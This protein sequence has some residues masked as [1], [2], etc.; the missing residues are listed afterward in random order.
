MMFC[1][2]FVLVVPAT[3]CF[4]A[5]VC[6]ADLLGV[7][8][9]GALPLW[10]PVFMILAA[11]FLHLSTSAKFCLISTSFFCI[12]ASVSSS[13]LSSM[14]AIPKTHPQWLYLKVII[15]GLCHCLRLPFQVYPLP[16]TYQKF[17]P[18]HQFS[19]TQVPTKAHS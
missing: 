19:R 4:C 16:H 8:F 14:P 1:F 15:T 13:L 2:L 9:I 6:F 10:L 7:C 3:G 5:P 17:F 11:S 18:V 12:S